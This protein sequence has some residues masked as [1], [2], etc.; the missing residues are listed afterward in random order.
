VASAQDI[1]NFWF[2][3]S[4]RKHWFRKSDVFDA[5]IRARF[6]EAANDLAANVNIKTPHPW[7]GDPDKT[8]ALII[9][10]DQFPRNMYRD[11]KA[12]FAWDGLALGVSERMVDNGHDLKIDQTRRSFCYMPYMHSEKM[13]DQNR[14]IELMD[15]RLEGND[16]IKH[17]RQHRQIIERFGRFPHRNK[18]LARESTAEEIKF[19]EDG[20]YSP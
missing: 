17:A 2:V 20:G 19:L 11:N 13:V 8:L 16:N 10:L 9:A 1:L 14:C 3:E 18:V 7:E 5:K 15:E 4:G 12:S 6:E